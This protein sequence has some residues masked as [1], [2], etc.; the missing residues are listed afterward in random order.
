MNGDA[1]LSIG[2]LARRTG[3][4]VKAVRSYS[5]RGIVPPAGRTPAG[6][7]RYGPEAVARLRWVRTLRALGVGL[8]AIREALDRG[9]PPGEI[10]AAHAAE[11]AE[12]IRELGARRAVL[13]TAAERDATP[14][15][16]ELMH[17]LAALTEDERQA[18]T[19]AFLDEV[20]GDL[21]R[22]PG[23][24]G[25]ARSMTPQLAEDPA[26]AEVA[27]WIE[28]AELSG[29]AAFRELMGRI[30]DH[31]VGD[32][33][34]HAD[35]VPRP[36]P[37]TVVCALAAPAHRAGV[38]PGSARARSVVDAVTASYAVHCGRPDDARLR[39]RLLDRLETVHDPRRERYAELLAVVNR[40]PAPEPLGPELG[41]FQEALRARATG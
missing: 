32:R 15:E 13:T 7:R 19:G 4:T 41:W 29:D 17:R 31:H 27:A 28:L 5:D 23:L 2:E 39:Q 26:E 34:V 14:E 20:F 9:T 24:P 1:H 11:L 35:G 12:R 33:A 8:A 22:A 21:G 18:L 25:V 10:A 40:W 16:W 30:V 6:Y 38:A 36:G 3:L 37:E